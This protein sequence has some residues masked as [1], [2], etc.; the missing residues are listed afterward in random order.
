MKG[1]EGESEGGDLQ[2]GQRGHAMQRKNERG[3]E[4]NGRSLE[5]G[6]GKGGMK[7]EGIKWCVF[8]G[9]VVERE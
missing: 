8:G 1:N 7:Y 9:K 3:S 4:K 2:N 5:I 6:R